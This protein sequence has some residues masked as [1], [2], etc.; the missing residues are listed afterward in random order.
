MHKYDF[1]HIAIILYDDLPTT[2]DNI[3]DNL[4]DFT[5][6]KLNGRY[7]L[8]IRITKDIDEALNSV[9][10]QN[11]EWAGVVSA[12]NYLQDQTLIMQTIEHAQKE[13]SPL[14]CHILDRGGYFHFHPQWFVLDLKK[15]HQVGRPHL[16]ETPGPVDLT[17][18]VTDRCPDNV[19][20]DYTPWWLRPQIGSKK[21]Y[22]SDYGYF[23]VKLISAFIDAGFNIV[24]IPQEARN[25]KNYCYPHH[26]YG[27]LE[28]I[29]KG[30]QFEIPDVAL[31]WFKKAIDQL[32]DGLHHGYYVLNT[33]HL[34]GDPRL[35]EKTFDCFIGV[36]GGIKPV[37]IAGKENF[38]ANSRVILFDISQAALDYQ[39]WLLEKW[40]GD[41]NNFESVWKEFQDKNTN[42]RPHY[43]SNQSIDNNI[44][45]FLDGAG[46][47]R[48]EFQHLWRRYQ[49]MRHEFV[50][51]D[52]LTSDSA[53]QIIEL[54]DDGQCSY[55]WTSNAFNMD[56]LMFYRTKKWC[57]NH[58]QEFCNIIGKMLK[59][60]AVLEDCGY[61][62]FFN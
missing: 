9:C 61:L 27:L 46:I 31:W 38:N 28:R 62:R 21:V 56:Y 17:T 57:E 37:C 55:I 36:C 41:F 43:F 22:T 10:D 44:S 32:T 39:Q 8:D 6:F 20:D 18:C 59:N 40:D 1:P 24:N 23:G 35:K 15:Y 7:Q 53:K 19:H 14:A 33:E 2:C 48:Q 52:L 45:W 5:E 3:R 47:D 30:E 12:G 50:H 4:I 29:I 25:R 11:H 34:N 16:K 51:L 54:I 49:G 26:N 13:N 42:Y 60:S 58:R